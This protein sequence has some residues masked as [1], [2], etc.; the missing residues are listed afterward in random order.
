MRLGTYFFATI[1]SWGANSR[2]ADSFVPDCDPCFHSSAC[3]VS[4]HCYPQMMTELLKEA[5]TLGSL[6]HPNIVWV[7][8]VVLPDVVQRRV[9]DRTAQRCG[10]G[11]P[12]LELGFPER[13]WVW[14]QTSWNTEHL[15]GNSGV[16][17]RLW[18]R[19]QS[20]WSFLLRYQLI[21]ARFLT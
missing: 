4:V 17:W 20:F 3:A 13:I 21:I 19:F 14:R 8:G 2:L 15:G 7:Y 6:R 1:F 18:G 11:S 9:Q 10:A 5:A 12:A 16:L